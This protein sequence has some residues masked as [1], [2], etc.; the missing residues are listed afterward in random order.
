[1]GKSG[2]AQTAATN[3]AKWAANS[4]RILQ[5]Q[6]ARQ[7]IRW[8]VED[9]Q[10]AGLHPLYALGGAPAT[11]T[12][13]ASQVSFGG[14]SDGARMGRAL[15]SA[16]QD[17]GRAVMAQATQQERE[18]HKANLALIASQI[19]ENDAR[20]AYYLSQAGRG[21]QN[22]GAPFPGFPSVPP[23]ATVFPIK[24]GKRIEEHPL[25]SGAVE[26]TAPPQMSRDPKDPSRTAARNPFWARH[27]V[28]P[29][30]DLHLPYSEEGPA[31]ALQMPWY[32]H[33]FLTMPKNTFE[34]LKDFRESRL[35]SRRGP[36]VS[37]R[38][39]R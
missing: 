24:G 7:G 6:F 27:E 28:M 17:V 12:P 11:Y 14:D 4:D 26:L 36:A 18:L 5:Q 34:W 20:R 23:S 35:R 19:G 32:A 13:S 21:G 8:R 30:F 10:A 9:A 39:R 2:G 29:G 1:M 38:I 22:V 25:H 16:G 37:G 3:A 31:E 33:L 15:A